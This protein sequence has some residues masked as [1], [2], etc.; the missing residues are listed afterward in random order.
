MTTKRV[1]PHSL[2]QRT[3]E[4]QCASC[5][6]V[7]ACPGHNF[8]LTCLAHQAVEKMSVTPHI[9]QNTFGKVPRKSTCTLCNAV[10]PWGGADFCPS[11]VAEINAHT[12]ARR[13][14]VLLAKKAGSPV[15]NSKPK[16]KRPADAA[17]KNNLS[18]SPYAAKNKAKEKSKNPT[19]QPILQRQ[20][21]VAC[22]KASPASLVVKQDKKSLGNSFLPSVVDW[23]SGNHPPSPA[24]KDIQEVEVL[25][26]R[27]VRGRSQSG[28]PIQCP[29]CLDWLLGKDNYIKH[30]KAL[31]AKQ[32]RKSKPPEVRPARE[33]KSLPYRCRKCG[34]SFDNEFARNQHVKDAHSKKYKNSNKTSVP[35][36]RPSVFSGFGAAAGWVTIVGGGLPG[37]GKRSR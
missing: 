9:T 26:E 5:R 29:V 31:H 1:I 10:G 16:P 13:K 34:D 2:G 6:G 3:D 28:K 24:P 4:Q 11:C 35:A 23:K 25:C 32:K 20:E 19:S 8:C 21:K 18:Y 12:K 37:L 30:F 22:N 7:R 33:E 17:L 14:G 36:G 15:V 27:P